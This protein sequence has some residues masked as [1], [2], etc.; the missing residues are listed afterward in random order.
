M[1]P[2]PVYIVAADGPARDACASAFAGQV[3]FLDPPLR[4]ATLLERAPG[5]VL[6][7]VEG[8]TALELLAAADALSGPEWTLA[9][10]VG[11]PLTVRTLSAGYET[12]LDQVAR[13]VADAGDGA[14]DLLELHQV[15]EEISR[16]RH[17]IN[18]P[19]TSALAETQIL[20]LDVAEGE[21]RESLETIQA[22]LRRIRDLVA[23]TRHLRPYR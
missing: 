1:A 15:L 7:D 17:D 12:R 20:L 19:L 13:F 5:V 2:K 3:E 4:F 23:A 14:E 18:N 22:Q 8:L 6:A 21:V 11:E 10:F 9:V 16:A